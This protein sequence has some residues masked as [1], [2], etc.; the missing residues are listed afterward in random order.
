M[1]GGNGEHVKPKKTPP[2]EKNS[3]LP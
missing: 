3:H 2:E 1:N